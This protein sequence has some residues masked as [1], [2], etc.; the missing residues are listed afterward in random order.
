[1]PSNLEKV[2]SRV[3]GIN[4]WN[5]RFRVAVACPILFVL[6]FMTGALGVSRF[7]PIDPTVVGAIGG[8]VCI[9]L[10]S[11]PLALVD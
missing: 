5:H 7:V 10:G 2:K 4:N 11:I 3:F 8:G 1:M 6:G 9:I